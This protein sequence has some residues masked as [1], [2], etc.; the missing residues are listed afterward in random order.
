VTTGVEIDAGRIATAV[1][2]GRRIAGLDGGRY[3]EIATH[4]PAGASA[5]SAPPESVTI[6]D[7][8]DRS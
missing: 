2:A 4:L 6:G 3:G 5:E 1:Q 8:V 7:T